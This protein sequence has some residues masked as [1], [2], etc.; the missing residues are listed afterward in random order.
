MIYKEKV[1]NALWAI[2]GRY[3]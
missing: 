2:F 3:T 1:K